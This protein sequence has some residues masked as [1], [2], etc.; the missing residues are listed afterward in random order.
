MLERVHVQP[1]LAAFESL[2]RD[3][4]ARLATFEDERFARPDRVERDPATGELTVLAEFITG[5]RLSD[6]LEATADAAIVPGVD[7][8]LGYLLESLPALTLLHHQRASRTGSSTRR[9]PSSRR[10]DSS[11]SSTRRSDRRSS[12]STCR[13]C[14]SGTGSASRHPPAM[15]PCTS[16]LPS[17][18]AQVALGARR[19]RPRPQP[20]TG[21]IP[22]SPAIAADG[23]DRGRA[24]SR[25]AR[26][27]RPA[28][29]VS[30]SD[31]CRFPDAVPTPLPTRRSTTCDSSCAA[32]SASTSAGRPS[33]T[34]RRRWTR[35]SPAM[36][37]TTTSRHDGSCRRT[38]T[39]AAHSPR[40]PELDEFLESFE[41]PSHG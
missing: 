38:A 36:P 31:R 39:P 26:A 37:P 1:E 21:R 11:S 40:V 32:R 6:L 3:R 9:A 34:S 19:A 20:A 28:C 17:D 2:I 22:R 29:S 24:D 30:S 7:V 25:H 23:S 5:S 13:A 8:A 4:V 35:H 16:T 41:S 27:S 10:M 18:I 15:A 14:V 12:V 33:S